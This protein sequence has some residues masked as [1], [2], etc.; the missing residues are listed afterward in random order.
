MRSYYL[1]SVE[2]VD[3]T[4]GVV[5]FGLPTTTAVGDI[6]ATAI[7][8]G[9][10]TSS[11]FSFGED[12]TTLFN[13]NPVQFIGPPMGEASN[14]VSPFTSNI[15][16]QGHTPTSNLTSPTNIPNILFLMQRG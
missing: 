15:L 12:V 9:P 4:A 7:I 3:S 2:G 6:V 8:I 16:M 13:V 14:L 1:L 10:V 11:S 5:A